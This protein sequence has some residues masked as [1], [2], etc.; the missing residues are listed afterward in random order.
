MSKV[1]KHGVNAPSG[2]DQQLELKYCERCG[3]LWLRELGCGA[4]YCVN[5]V[6][7][8]EE[9]PA[10]RKPPQGTRHGTGPRLPAGPTSD[11]DW[12]VDDMDASW[13]FRRVAGDL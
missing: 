9:L 13:G 11:E 6:G 10:P 7:A 3:G 12:D 8:M 4:V 2:Q 5:C 1:G